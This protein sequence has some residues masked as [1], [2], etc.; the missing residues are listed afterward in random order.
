MEMFNLNDLKN[1]FKVNTL[2][3]KDFFAVQRLMSLLFLLTTRC[4]TNDSYFLFLQKLTRSVTGIFPEET[5][6]FNKMTSNWLVRLLLPCL[7]IIEL[8]ISPWGRAIQHFIKRI[9]TSEGRIPSFLLPCECIVCGE[10]LNL[11]IDDY[12]LKHGRIGLEKYKHEACNDNWRT[13]RGHIERGLVGAPRLFAKSENEQLRNGYLESQLA[14]VLCQWEGYKEL[15]FILEMNRPYTPR[16]SLFDEYKNVDHSWYENLLCD[17][18]KLRDIDLPLFR[19]N[20]RAKVLDHALEL[21]DKISENRKVKISQ[22]ETYFIS[23][24]ERQAGNPASREPSKI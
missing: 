9:D 3:E 7:F 2:D 22:L 11:T 12:N 16:Y 6:E 13:I 21:P 17:K 20:I 10:T 15:A 8:E 19:P 18:I 14:G 5:F 24:V 23:P 4:E 1:E